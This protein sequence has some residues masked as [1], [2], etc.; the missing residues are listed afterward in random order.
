MPS[1][2][3]RKKKVQEIIDDVSDEYK[4]AAHWLPFS[5]LEIKDVFEEEELAVIK[6]FIAEIQASTDE[7]ERNAILMDNITKYGP[8]VLK[9]LSL[10]RIV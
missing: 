1:F 3:S 7:N 4:N 6:E 9:A 5:A 10:A 8:V 2:S